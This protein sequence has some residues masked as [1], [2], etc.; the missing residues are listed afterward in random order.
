[1]IFWL[2]E[3]ILGNEDN[4]HEDRKTDEEDGEGE[5]APALPEDPW[6]LLLS[7]A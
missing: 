5:A 6:L 7:T 3:L 2:Q 4:A 1:M